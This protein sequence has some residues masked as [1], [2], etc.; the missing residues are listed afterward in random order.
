M[1]GRTNTNG[2]ASGTDG[3]ANSTRREVLKDVGAVGTAGLAGVIG[4]RTARAGHQTGNFDAHDLHT[5]DAKYI[6]VYRDEYAP[7][8]NEWDS[9]IDAW[10]EAME[11]YLNNYLGVNNDVRVINNYGSTISYIQS[12]YDAIPNWTQLPHMSFCVIENWYEPNGNPAHLGR[13]FPNIDSGSGYFNQ[14]EPVTGYPLPQ[15]YIQ[16]EMGRILG[17]ILG[18]QTGD[19]EQWKNG[20]KLEFTSLATGH[21]MNM[22]DAK[23]ATTCEGDDWQSA[24]LTDCRPKRQFSDCTV[25]A[26]AMDVLDSVSPNAKYYWP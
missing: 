4:T 1:H 14:I 5:G 12:G 3:G 11:D 2:T 20:G 17:V 7:Y 21:T 10:G 9:A 16:P 24:G 25:Q 23:P 8:K 19:A 26:H 13:P 22:A 6:S 18:A 15:R